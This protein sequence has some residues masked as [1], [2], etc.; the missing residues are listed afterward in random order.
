MTAKSL[1]LPASLP[2]RRNRILAI[3][4]SM[5]VFQT[6][7]GAALQRFAAHQTAP[8]VCQPARLV[9]QHPLPAET[10]L[11]RQERALGTALLVG[12]A[13]VRSLRVPAGLGSLALESA[14]RWLRATWQRRMKNGSPTVT[15]D[16]LEDGFSASPAASLVAQVGTGMLLAFK[17]PS[18]DS[19]TDVFRLYVIVGRAV[20]GIQRL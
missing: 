15:R 1:C 2:A 16:L 10:C 5:T 7:M 11:L 18:A 20:R 14:W 17:R 12:M 8:R 19:G 9:L 3:S 13:I 4:R 6:R